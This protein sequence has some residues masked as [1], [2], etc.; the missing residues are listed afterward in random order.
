MCLGVLEI[1]MDRRTMFELKIPVEIL[2]P[3]LRTMGMKGS[4]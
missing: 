2:N 1:L 3:P 4:V